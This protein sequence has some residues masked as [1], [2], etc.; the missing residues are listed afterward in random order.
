MTSSPC[1]S[2]ETLA[3]YVDGRIGEHQLVEISNH[4]VDCE[5][6]YETVA[7]SVRVL[8]GV[9][10]TENIAPP[11]ALLP[12]LFTG[13]VMAVALTVSLLLLLRGGS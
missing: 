3:A 12:A 2:A 4:L 9:G 5:R 1:L 6:C 7:A 13:A 10:R 8:S 11:W